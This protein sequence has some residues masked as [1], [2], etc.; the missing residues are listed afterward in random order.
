[1][2]TNW[3]Y[4]YLQTDKDRL[5]FDEGRKRGWSLPAPARLAL[6]VWGIRHLRSF[7]HV[8]QAYHDFDEREWKLLWQKEWVGYAIKRGWV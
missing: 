7:W 1:M 6:R 5:W 2:P 8:W 3:G 4:T